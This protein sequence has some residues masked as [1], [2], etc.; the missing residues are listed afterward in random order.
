MI[1]T[2]LQLNHSV[3]IEVTINGKITT[4]LSSIEKIINNTILLTPIFIGGK[5]VGFPPQYEVSF[6][7]MEEKTETVYCWKNVSIKAVRYQGEIYHC[8]SLTTTGEPCNR[9]G[10]FRVF[11]GERMNLISFGTNG[12]TTH[13]VFIKDISETGMAF[14]SSE[15]FSVKHTIRLNLKV[16]SGQIVPLSAQIVRTQPTDAQ[17]E[18]LYGCRLL[19]KNPLLSKY[20]I[21]L[22]QEQQKK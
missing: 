3:E 18:V 19:E 2:E 10:A 6:L 16:F 8:V 11:I 5:I 20:L 1:A 13:E 12:P 7:Y 22:Q 15:P 4:L 17:G 14:I 9:R 21:K